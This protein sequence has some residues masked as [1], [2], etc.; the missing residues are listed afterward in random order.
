MLSYLILQGSDGMTALHLAAKSGNLE[1]CTLL[2]TEHSSATPRTLL[3]A[4]DDGGWTAL[5]WACE[6]SHF[7][8][9]K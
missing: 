8:I 1:A 9:V 2:L 3:D 4:Q 7:T 6:H 5:V